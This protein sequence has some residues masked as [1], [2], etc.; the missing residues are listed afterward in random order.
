MERQPLSRQSSFQLDVQPS[1]ERQPLSRQSSFQ[2]DVQ[3]SMERQPLSR[4]S[5]LYI[6]GDITNIIDNN[7]NFDEMFSSDSETEETAGWM[8]DYLAAI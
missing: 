8:D 6:A 1:M 5:S 4:Q 2:L 7:M 3:P